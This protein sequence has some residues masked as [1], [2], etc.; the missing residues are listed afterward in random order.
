MRP[1]TGEVSC[2][3]S[4]AFSLPDDKRFCDQII[5]LYFDDTC[6]VIGCASGKK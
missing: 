3:F 4:S 6:S 5:G 2:F 1:R